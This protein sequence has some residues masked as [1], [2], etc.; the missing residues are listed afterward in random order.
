MSCLLT[1]VALQSR[2]HLGPPDHIL[3][4]TART[5]LALG[6]TQIVG[7]G[8]LYYAFAVVAD[9]LT[10]EIGV[11]MPFA[12]GA[13]SLALLAGGAIAP[14]IGRTIDR[15]GARPVMALGSVAAALALVA[16][17]LAQGPVSL[18][19]ALIL[20]ELVSAAVLYDAAF[21][22]LAQC[23]GA[24]G[25]RRAITLMTL[26]G[27]FASTVFWPV[28]HMLATAVDWRTTYL[29]FAGLHVGLCLPLHLSLGRLASLTVAATSTQAAAAALLSDASQ[30]RAMLWLAIGLSLGGLVLSAMTVQW[31]PLLEATGL[32]AAAA[33]A[34]GTL[35]GPAQVGVRIIDLVFG[36]RQHP[37]TMAMIS[38]GLLVL[39]IGLLV[40]M[41]TG[42]AGAM[43]FAVVFGLASGLTSIVR[44][45]VPLALFGAKGYAARLGL[46]A[47]LRL[48]AS[49]LAP[50][51]LSLSLAGLGVG[52]TL[53]L[54]FGIAFA[55]F[56]ALMLVPRR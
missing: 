11:S 56:L 25:A 17:A 45:T 13:F 54:A 26:I 39:S 33:V 31:V 27:G 29:I 21:A 16:L 1:S 47:G 19:A 20:V 7:Y 36:V 51:A 37:M 34:A 46:L 23:A 50:F 48:A 15:Y 8:T 30:P 10:A 40:A 22:A 53:S 55:A 3:S 4:P 5:I 42:L 32:T 49:A 44:G 24:A 28:T 9:R 43:I 6:V 18:V 12:F 2:S 35:L 41:P 38:A 14:V 52:I